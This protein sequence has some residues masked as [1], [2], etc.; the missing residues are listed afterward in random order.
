MSLS[1]LHFLSVFQIRLFPKYCL[2]VF[3]HLFPELGSQELLLQPQV[4]HFLLTVSLTDFCIVSRIKQGQLLICTSDLAW[5]TMS[6]LSLGC[7]LCTINKIW[8][9][10]VSSNYLYLPFPET[11]LMHTNVIWPCE[12]RFLGISKYLK[13]SHLSSVLHKITICSWHRWRLFSHVLKGYLHFR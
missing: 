2:Q 6:I 10:R 1:W 9:S 12:R 8:D 4:L 13:F 3:K 11:K 7:I 5:M